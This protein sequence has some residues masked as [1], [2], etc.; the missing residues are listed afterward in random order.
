MIIQL[1]QTKCNC[2]QAIIPNAGAE[3]A[4]RLAGTTVDFCVTCAEKSVSDAAKTFTPQ[5]KP[6]GMQK[7]RMANGQTVMLPVAA[8]L[9][10]GAIVVA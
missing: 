2:C 8:P 4:V 7:V 9:P 3:G 6:G 10:N 1:Q 5:P